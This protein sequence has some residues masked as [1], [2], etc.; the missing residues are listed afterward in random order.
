LEGPS[1]GV[2]PNRRDD[3]GRA[4]GEAADADDIVIRATPK[5]TK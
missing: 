4:K 1:Y 2:G 5:Q 3:G